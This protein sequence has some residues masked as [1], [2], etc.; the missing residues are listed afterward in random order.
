MRAGR[1][2][3]GLPCVTSK[4]SVPLA[5]GPLLAYINY[6]LAFVSD[7]PSLRTDLTLLVFL[8]RL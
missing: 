3:P 1:L 5:T 8:L 2:H 4:S 7:N 6:E